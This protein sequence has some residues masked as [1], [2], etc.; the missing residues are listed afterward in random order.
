[1]ASLR[2]I[3][4]RT[5]KV[6]SKERFSMKSSGDSV[7][8]SK[9][10]MGTSYGNFHMWSFII[11]S[12]IVI[13]VVGWIVRLG[14]KKGPD[15]E[16]SWW[17]SLDK[18]DWGSSTALWGGLF[19]VSIVLFGWAG[20]STVSKM[21]EN[22]N[23]RWGVIAGFVISMAI[24]VT[25]FSVLFSAKDKNEAGVQTAFKSAAWMAVF[26]AVL[27][28]ALLYPIW[29]NGQARVAMVPYLIWVTA[30]AALLWDMKNRVV[31]ES[32]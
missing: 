14:L 22:D 16:Q 32:V 31:E 7:K 23:K 12:I 3:S 21:D 26:A 29:D 15:G 2:N 20:A 13:A 24:I 6:G 8:K 25:M 27:G 9:S 28:F 17:D 30:A 5:K 1:M 18:Y 19:V 11:I 10:W 4:E